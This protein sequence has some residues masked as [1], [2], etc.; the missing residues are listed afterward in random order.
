VPDAVGSVS[1][2]F[3][4]AP[5]TSRRL[6]LI[7]LLGATVI[8]T[9]VN[10]ILNVP[11]RDIAGD[12]GVPLS[13]GVLVVTSFALFLAAGLPLTGWVGDR[14]GRRRILIAALVLM[15]VG[16]LAAAV[17]PTFGLL[18]ASRAMQGI[19]C[20]VFPPAV[21]AILSTLYGTERRARVMS[22]WA[23]ANGIGQAIGPP[24]GGL[25]ADAAGWRAIFWV[26]TPVTALV[27]WG[28]W[29][30]IPGDAGRVT[31]LHWPGAAS[32]TIGAAL[33]MASATAVP[34]RGVP[35]W[36]CV[37]LAGLGVGLL[38]FF[39]VS[40]LDV[41]DPVVRPR[42]IVESRF[43]RSTVAAASQM[44]CLACALV[45]VPLYMTG[46]LGRSTALT[47]MCVL[48]L[49]ATMA[50]LAPIVGRLCETLSP[51]WVLRSGLLVLAGSE[52]VLG[53]YLERGG[54]NLAFLVGTL[55]CV[56]AGVALVQTP[57]ATG[58]TRSPAGCYGASLGLFNMLRFAG[59]ALG[60]AWVAVVYPHGA[61][62]VL[63]VVA[64]VLAGAGFWASF[65]GPD[66]AAA[67]RYAEPVTS[68]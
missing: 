6:A 36:V 59:S 55:I 47:G 32:L 34:Q 10:N 27:A 5:P 52:L 11:L 57:A 40:S 49:P 45:A 19:A 58:A 66:P 44:F 56:G 62:L 68:D 63:F 33:V 20:A 13:S 26:L 28:S 22:A 65:A 46:T 30:V 38:A 53:G 15:T 23:A 12:F 67:P 24:L 31:P 48:A 8:G 7:P 3:P 43:L 9:V 21:M 42:L 50:V 1:L 17:A 29:R 61:M 64:S 18:V 14:F 51:R 16:T 2:A 41:A 39:V 54:R 4:A 25:L 60:A 37:L 35:V